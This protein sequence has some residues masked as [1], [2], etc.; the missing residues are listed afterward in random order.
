MDA[1]LAGDLPHHP[2]PLDVIFLLTVAR[3]DPKNVDS[4]IQ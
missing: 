2:D 4:G 1:H 3:I